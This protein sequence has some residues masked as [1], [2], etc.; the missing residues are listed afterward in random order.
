MLYLLVLVVV[1]MII[2][3][4][5]MAP[6]YSALEWSVFGIF[7][8]VI[9]LVGTNYFFGV[10]IAAR[11]KDPENPKVDIAVVSGAPLGQ[12]YH[13]P[14]RYNY[15]EAKALCRAYGGKLATIDQ[16]QDAY[17]RGAEWCNYGWSDDAM[18]LFP[19]QTKTWSEFN[20]TPHKQD[21]GRPGVNGGY[22]ND[23]NQRLGANCFGPKP[24]QTADIKPPVFPPK[25]GD[26]QVK[27]FE[28]N[29]PPVAPFNYTRWSA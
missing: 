24:A 11:L 20:D 8:I 18:V 27:Y 6:E 26:L 14:G 4:V 22:N 10:D 2:G 21:C 5:V 1:T 3:I 9:G 16:V 29:P 28:K 13:V 12:T 17:L 7:L 23:L 15:S 19:T 25:P